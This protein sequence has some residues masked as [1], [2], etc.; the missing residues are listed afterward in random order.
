MYVNHLRENKIKSEM[1]SM[2]IHSGRDDK[3]TL[4]TS[5]KE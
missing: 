4:T 2:F 1:F 5:P 3:C